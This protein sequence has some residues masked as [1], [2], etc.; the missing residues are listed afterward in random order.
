MK[1]GEQ[2]KEDVG[3]QRKDLVCN[4]VP[5]DCLHDPTVTRMVPACLCAIIRALL[6][7]PSLG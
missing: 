2:N 3:S 5:E 1:V 4:G 6:F 7:Y